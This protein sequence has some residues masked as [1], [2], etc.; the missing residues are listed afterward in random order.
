VGIGKRIVRS[1]RAVALVA[2]GAAGG[3]VAFAVA[4]VPDGTGIHACVRTGAGGLPDTSA[5][6][7]TVIDPAAGQSC[8][9]PGTPGVPPTTQLPLNWNITGPQGPQGPPGAPGTR[10]LGGPPGTGNTYT[11]SLAPAVVNRKSGLGQVTMDPGRGGFSF[12]LLS[13]GL[14]VG[15]SLT[16]GGGSSAGGARKVS[17]HDIIITKLVD[18]S[19]PKLFQA[20]VSGKHFATVKIELAK[21]GKVYLRITLSSV[22]IASLQQNGHGGDK[23]PSESITLNFTKMEIAY[24]K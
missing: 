21:A 5:A 11:V 20:L 12:P 19:S 7:L 24:K 13:E 18:K 9:I 10:G 4:S 23:P 6:N 17:L 22:V 1:W 16:S 14:V 8:T 15:S 2:V 3:G